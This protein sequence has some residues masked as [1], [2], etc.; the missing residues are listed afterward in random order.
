[1]SLSLAT[2]EAIPSDADSI[3]AVHLACIH[4]IC[5]T[6]YNKDQVD[7]WSK[8]S[9]PEQ[10]AKH[11]TNEDSVFLV[12]EIPTK[13]L[14]GFAHFGKS[15]D[16]RFS[17]KVDFEIYGFYVSPSHG[18][19]GVGKTLMAEVERQAVELGRKGDMGVCSTLNA[20]PFYE[21]CGFVVIKDGTRCIG[22]ACQGLESKIMEKIM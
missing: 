7:T 15:K 9:T 10:F 17:N 13:E 3:H 2:R 8:R 22:G 16:S 1:M 14:I 19:K 12:A 21:K 11:I 5:S 4:E 20:V 18:R 6:F